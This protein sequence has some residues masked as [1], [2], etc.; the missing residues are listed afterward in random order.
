[1]RKKMKIIENNGETDVSSRCP[2][3]L[4]LSSSESP[5]PPHS[6]LKNTASSSPAL[7]D[8]Q[9]WLWQRSKVALSN[10]RFTFVN[11]LIPFF[12]QPFPFLRRGSCWCRKF[13][14]RWFN[15]MLATIVISEI[16]WKW[17]GQG[18]GTRVRIRAKAALGFYTKVEDS[19]WT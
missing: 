10:S 9:S 4:F 14:R 16:K 12:L 7:T 13:R 5:P 19:E 17:Q 15:T 6:R 11:Y 3:F 2:L 18:G 8:H 1:M